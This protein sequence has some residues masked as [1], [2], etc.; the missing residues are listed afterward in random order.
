MDAFVLVQATVTLTE[1]ILR[2]EEQAV[3][4][5]LESKDKSAKL[6]MSNS[7]IGDN[8]VEILTQ[9]ICQTQ[10]SPLRPHLGQLPTLHWDRLPLLNKSQNSR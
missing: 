5:V 8:A 3:Y 7:S 2:G 9:S 10:S 6:T 1:Q 4:L